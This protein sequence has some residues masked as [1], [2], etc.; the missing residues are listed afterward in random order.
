MS[1]PDC[2]NFLSK[3]EE[4][5]LGGSG[6]GGRKSKI[7]GKKRRWEIDIKMGKETHQDDFPEV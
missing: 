2:F 7:W 4:K 3:E 6:K 1:S 5:K